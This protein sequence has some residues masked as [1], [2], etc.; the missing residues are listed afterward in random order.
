MR[1]RFHEAGKVGS[2]KPAL[3]QERLKYLITYD[4]LTGVFLWKNPPSPSSVKAGDVAGYQNGE[5]Y[6][7]ICVDG[8]HYKTSRLAWFYHHGKWPGGVADH[9]DTDRGN[10]RIGNLRDV[11][12]AINNENTRKAR[13]SNSLG[14]LG[15]S[16]RP[17]LGMYLSQIQVLGVKKYLGLFET[18]EAAS[19]AYLT[20]KR[21]MHEGCTL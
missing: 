21:A 20:A 6:K 7:R 9:K 4:P 13:S 3:T 11:T 18:A 14:V 5:G 17:D 12:R 15:V 10:D 8:A 1:H 19:A 16:Y 2:M